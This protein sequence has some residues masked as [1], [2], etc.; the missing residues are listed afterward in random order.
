MRG[1]GRLGC[2]RW[3][4]LALIV[5]GVVSQH[6][7]L[8]T[9]GEVGAHEHHD[10]AGGHGDHAMHATPC[11]VVVAKTLSAGPIAPAVS[12]MVLDRAATARL[13][14]DVQPVASAVVSRAGPPLYVLHAS[15]LI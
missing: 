13:Q 2:G 15:L 7:V 1:R 12:G 5:V 6:C 14:S 10:A 4:V 8:P 3:L 11:D 9:A